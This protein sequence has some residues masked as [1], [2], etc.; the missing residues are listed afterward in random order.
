M[1][2]DHATAGQQLYRLWLKLSKYPLGKWIFSRLIGWKIPYTG[3]I[4]ADVMELSPGI[5]QVRLKPRRGNYNHLNSIHAIALSNLGELASGLAVL[6]GLP[7]TVRGIVTRIE[8]KYLKKARGVLMAHA[9]LD[10]PVIS[11]S[12]VEHEVEARIIDADGDVVA[13]IRANWLLSESNN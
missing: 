13:V 9:N 4:K 11:S 5:A 3:S 2:K 1:K 10:L 8:T 7:K 12:S 6:V